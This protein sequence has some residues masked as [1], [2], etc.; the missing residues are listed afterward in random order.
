MPAKQETR[1][2]LSHNITFLRV[3]KSRH[4]DYDIQFCNEYQLSNTSVYIIKM[5]DAKSIKTVRVDD[6]EMEVTAGN[7]R[8]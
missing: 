8:V 3:E 6:D 5:Q 2:I 4:Y 1:T 7:K